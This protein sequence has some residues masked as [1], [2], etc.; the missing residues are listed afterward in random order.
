M[1]LAHVSEPGLPIYTPEAKD[2]DLAL[3]LELLVP[4]QSKYTG[5]ARDNEM[6]KLIYVDREKGCRR[7]DGTPQCPCRREVGG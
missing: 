4:E 1:R 5:L 2:I 6:T 3:Y 7:S